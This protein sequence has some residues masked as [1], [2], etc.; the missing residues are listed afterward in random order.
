MRPI[1]AV[2]IEPN[3][4]EEDMATIVSMTTRDA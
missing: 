1:G 4:E 3:E 2:L